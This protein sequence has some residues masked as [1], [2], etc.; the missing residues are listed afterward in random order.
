MFAAPP[1]P[2]ADVR[3]DAAP[4]AYDGPERRRPSPLLAAP[5]AERWTADRLGELAIP[6]D[7]LRDCREALV[8]E[9]RDCPDFRD[10]VGEL[11][12]EGPD[13]VA[14]RA[15]G[16]H[17][18]RFDRMLSELVA[19]ARACG[20]PYADALDSPAAPRTR[21]KNPL[22]PVVK[23][24]SKRGKLRDAG[25]VTLPLIVGRSLSEWARVCTGAA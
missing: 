3:P 19:V 16:L 25:G 8:R 17:A 20:T 9:C 11:V 13:A 2:P 4:A 24:L 6:R 1:A 7:A 14:R 22:R 23:R 12:A 15:G 10:A 21:A 5:A 18:E